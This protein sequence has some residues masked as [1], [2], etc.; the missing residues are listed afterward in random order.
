MRRGPHFAIR[1]IREGRVKILG[2]FYEPRGESAERFN[3]QRA[4]F[5]LYWGAPGYANY[6]ERGLMDSCCLWGSEAMYR[7]AGVDDDS[8]DSEYNRL[9]DL[10]PFCEDGFFKWEWWKRV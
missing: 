10:N 8:D 5:G 2:H 4:A 3:G 9:Y 1:T 7:A 6:D